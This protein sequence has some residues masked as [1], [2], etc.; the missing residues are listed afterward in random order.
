MT[1]FHNHRVVADNLPWL[2]DSGRNN[3]YKE[4]IQNSVRGKR[5]LEVGAGAGLLMQYALDA[6]AEHVTGVE[7]RK[8]R[9][10]FLGRL[11]QSQGHKNYSILNKD[12]MCLDKSVLSDV[13]VVI[14]EQTG[15]QFKND[16]QLMRV[17]DKLKDLDVVGIPDAYNIDVHVFDGKVEKAMPLVKNDSIPDT[18]ENAVKSM[19]ITDP[20]D[21]FENIW[22]TSISKGA[23][24]ITMELD[25][26]GYKDCTLYIDD[27]VSFRGKR[28]PYLTG[29]ENWNK[30]YT[31][32]IDDAKGIYD[33][34]F[35]DG[36]W[37]HKRK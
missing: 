5:V 11:F 33:I 3:F 24:P 23:I 28:C 17:F 26:T 8:E 13:D 9:A 29:Y 25:L 27:Y 15:D 37:N 30:P 19:V 36:K 32:H 12:F 2:N 22:S 18:Y 20:T 4:A 35:K 1:I 31:Y 21:S 16:C 6:G 34:Y 7:I 14:C 10:K